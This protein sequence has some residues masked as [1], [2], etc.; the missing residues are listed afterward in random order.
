MPRSGRGGVSTKP[1]QAS[2][3]RSIC[4]VLN[5]RAKSQQVLGAL[6]KRATGR[7]ERSLR[8]LLA[9]DNIVNQRWRSA[10]DRI[11]AMTS[12]VA[13]YTARDAGCARPPGLDV[14]LMTCRCPEMADSKRQSPSGSG[15]RLRRRQRGLV[16]DDGAPMNGDRE[17]CLSA[18]MDATCRSRSI[19]PCS[20]APWSTSRPR[21]RVHAVRPVGVPTPVD[22]HP[23]DGALGGDQQLLTGHHSA[24][25]RRLSRALARSI[26]VDA[27]DAA[28]IRTTGA[29]LQGRAGNLAAGTHVRGTQT[30]ERWARKAG[31]RRRR[32]VAPVVDGGR[33]RRHALRQ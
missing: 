24:V 14:V 27:R 3:C 20:T 22:S 28:R 31:S 32:R 7:A 16:R 23:P 25:P 12:P 15:E 10:V 5:H 30:L 21:A 8:V 29:R 2:D 1:I 13:K 26:R 17:R 11:E 9:E 19:P 6:P 33:V 18:G 4:R